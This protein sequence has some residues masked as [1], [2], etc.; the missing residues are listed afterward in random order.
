MTRDE[1]ERRCGAVCQSASHGKCAFMCKETIGFIDTSAGLDGS[2]GIAFSADAMAVNT[3]GFVREISYKSISSVYVVESFEN[4]FADELIVCGNNYEIRI[5]DYSLDKSELKRLIEE[6]CED[7]FMDSD[8]VLGEEKEKLPA[9][10]MPNDEQN[11]RETSSVIS[12]IIGGLREEN[13][14]PSE[15]QSRDIGGDVFAVN[16]Y[17]QNDFTDDYADFQAEQVFSAAIPEEIPKMLSDENNDG[18]DATRETDGS[19]IADDT[20]IVE[21]NEADEDGITE[22]VS[23]LTEDIRGEQAIPEEV[24]FSEENN[25]EQYAMRETDDSVIADDTEIVDTNEA[26]EDGIT[27]SV[28]EFMEDICGEQ[29][30][31]DEIPKMLSEENNDG[32]DATRETD[33]SVIA[34][35]T[36]IVDT[37]EAD[38]DGITESVS[39]LMEDI[40]GEQAISDEIP[41]MFSEENNDGQDTT[42]ETDDSVIADD[43][44]IAET[45]EADEDGIIESVSEFT[46]N[47][48]YNDRGFPG[49]IPEETGADAVFDGDKADTAVRLMQPQTEEKKTFSFKIVGRSEAYVKY[50]D[51]FDEQAELERIN[52]MSRE[53]TMSYIADAFAEINGE[54]TED[55]P[56][57]NAIAYAEEAEQVIE[58]SPVEAK[59]HPEPK[60]DENKEHLTVEPSWGDIYIKASRSLR[61]L[62][63]QGKL[64]MNS[65]REELRIRLV[66]SAEA[67]AAITADESKIPKV[68]MPMI[69]ELRNAANN[70]DEYFSYGEDIGTRAMFFMM[71]QMLS[72]ADRIVEDPEV[73]KR[74]NDFF[75]RF[76]SAGIILSMLDKR[77]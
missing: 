72:Y 17:F 43:S 32:Q 52:A 50:K 2:R 19:V 12:E 51:D 40:R 75:R 35:D 18:Q 65:I 39:E 3:D 23:E 68:L 8:D 54:N 71:F 45:N 6:L 41:K 5:S 15:E 56:N 30:I 37:N 13:S 24:G 67:F 7:G 21:T 36:E 73:K 76:G 47:D 69:T 20:E 46:E 58:G 11:E 26:D 61:E 63:E 74:H 66:P 77:V 10:D 44:E 34:D 28:N 29:A 60:I 59:N 64:S 31:S 27:E 55:I 4:S 16:S 57:E 48:M 14:E 33:D 42:R 1:I 25:D 9:E 62:C 22:S 70:F 38:E 53:Q 49:V